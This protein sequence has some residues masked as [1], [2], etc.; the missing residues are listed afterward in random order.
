[1]DRCPELQHSKIAT[2][3]Y[4]TQCKNIAKKVIKIHNIG[5]HNARIKGTGQRGGLTFYAGEYAWS[6]T[7][8]NME[9]VLFVRRT[10]T[11]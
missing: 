6:D 2:L 5:Y 8:S 4:F 7:T 11:D 9:T 3:A 10:F 1:M